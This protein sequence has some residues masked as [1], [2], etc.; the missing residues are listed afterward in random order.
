MEF[1]L[2]IAVTP[3]LA[4]ILT[5][6]TRSIMPISTGSPAEKTS[7]KS[8]TENGKAPAFK[9]PAKA[10]VPVDTDDSA[11]DGELTLET[12]TDLVRDKLDKNKQKAI[13]ALLSEFEVPKASALDPSQYGDFMAKLE[14]I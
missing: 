1:T 7:S 11:A 9:K 2:T 5:D 3:E 6:Y 4:K 13:K 8:V 12:I 14:K 10:A